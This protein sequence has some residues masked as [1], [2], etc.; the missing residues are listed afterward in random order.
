M[1][2]CGRSTPAGLRSTS[3]APLT[4][5]N[6][7]IEARRIEK[8]NLEA[9]QDRAAHSTTHLV[10]EALAAALPDTPAERIEFLTEQLR[11]RVDGRMSDQELVDHITTKG[12]QTPL[13]L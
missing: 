11:S 7:E 13:P 4:G 3:A 6:S 1:S 9:D 12:L 10:S 2:G 8:A 5:T